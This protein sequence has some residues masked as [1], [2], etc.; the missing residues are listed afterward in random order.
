V[1]HIWVYI[2][3]VPQGTR[4][5]PLLPPVTNGIGSAMGATAMNQNRTKLHT[6]DQIIKGS[7]EVALLYCGEVQG[8]D[9]PVL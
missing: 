6:L 8:A 2:G 4:L 7:A 3:I 5:I 1:F 9:T